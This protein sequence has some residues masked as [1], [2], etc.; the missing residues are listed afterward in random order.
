MSHP[1]HP[2]QMKVCCSHRKACGRTCI[3]VCSEEEN[4][5]SFL[6]WFHVCHWHFALWEASLRTRSWSTQVLAWSTCRSILSLAV[7]ADPPWQRS[8]VEWGVVLDTTIH[9]IFLPLSFSNIFSHGG[10]QLHIFGAIG[11]YYPRDPVLGFFLRVSYLF[12]WL[13]GS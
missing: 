8:R 9:L 7:F 1:L 10:Q 6:K 11:V 5:V 3:V 13:K 4:T 2:L 12:H